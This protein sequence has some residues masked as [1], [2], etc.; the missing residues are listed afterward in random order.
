MN[1]RLTA[2]ALFS[3]CAGVATLSGQQNPVA[4]AKATMAKWVETRQIISEEKSD[5]EVEQEFLKS[6]SELLSAQA[7]SLEEQVQE[8]EDS[9]TESDKMR[10]ELLIERANLQRADTA[11]VQKIAEMEADLLSLVQQFPEPLKKKLEPLIVRIPENPEEATLSLGQRLVNILGILGQAE[12]FNSTANFYGE[13][14][15][16][17]D[18]QIQVLTLYWGLGFA[19]Y[20]DSQGKVAGFGTPGQDGWQWT[21]D[22]SI[23]GDAKR[24]MDMY[25]GNTDVIEFVQL[26]IQIK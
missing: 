22:N 1:I 17:G 5:W 24:F 10:N 11:M 2:I 8:L 6:T 3:C 19:I 23:A 14:R 21:E 26:P 18:Q 13:T 16:V 25:E 4:D 15:K 7:A 20:V 9:T 12:K